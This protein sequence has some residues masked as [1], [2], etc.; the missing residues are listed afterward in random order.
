MKKHLKKQPKNSILNLKKTEILEPLKFADVFFSVSTLPAHLKTLRKWRD[1]VALGTDKTKGFNPAN[2]LYDHELTV[3]LLE[4]AWLL[5]KM[6]PGKLNIDKESPKVSKWYFRTEQK[7]LKHYPKNLK[8]SEIIK[9]AKVLKKVF[10]PFN[11][12]Q[13][14]EIL[15]TWLYDATSNNFLEESLS[16]HEVITVYEQLVR[17]FEAMWLINSR[18]ETIND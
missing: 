2:L 9:P 16:K 8:T 11:L 13:Y 15:N 14:R 7:K 17:L 10:K 6:N 5:K 3:K 18:K 4:A 1:D 12:T